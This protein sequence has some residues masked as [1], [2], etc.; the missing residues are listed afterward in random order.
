[1]VTVPL[2]RPRLD[3]GVGVEAALESRRSVREFSAEELS[4][5]HLSQ[6]L[7]AA[8]GVTRGGRGRTVPSAGAHYPM[9]LYVVAGDVPGLVPGT[10]RYRPERHDLEH[11]RAGDVRAEL[12]DAALQQTWMVGAPLVIV[13]T[14]VFSRTTGEYGDRGRHY[15]FMEVGSVYQNVHL[16]AATLNLGTTVVG[17]FE[18]ER[19]ARLLGLPIDHEP[20]V[21]MPVGKVG[22]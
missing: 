12:A 17:A 2:P 16:Q 13:V 15:V 5:D 1:M 21:M 10:Y 9:E 6:L 4:L 3:G 19:V 7:W 11:R 8:Q 22:R 14:A 20:L 18:D